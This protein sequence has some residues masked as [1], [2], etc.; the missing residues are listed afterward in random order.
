MITPLDNYLLRAYLD[1]EMDEAT[2]E[3]FEKQMIERPELAELVIADIALSM[4]M[5]A[6]AT[7]LASLAVPAAAPATETPTPAAAPEAATPRPPAPAGPPP[8]ATPA[9]SS[10]KV[11]PLRRRSPVPFLAA[12]GIALAAGLGLGR[13][14]QPGQPMLTGADLATVDTFRGAATVRQVRLPQADTL[15]L[16]IAVA[17]QPE[18]Q[19]VSVR[20]NQSGRQWETTAT[21][22]QEAYVSVIADAR[23]LQAGRAE[24]SLAC[25][26]QTLQTT[27]IDF[28][29]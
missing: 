24:V 27:P 23:Q 16:G 1:R 17:A 12:A 15:V 28:V 6:S 10:G 21:L 4:G 18:C 5:K 7:E 9:D 29:H 2:A 25:A 19:R 26:G 13:M 8:A 11:V 22:D 3:A 20:L 14:L